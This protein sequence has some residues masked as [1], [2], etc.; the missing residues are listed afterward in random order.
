MDVYSTH[1]WRTRRRTF[2]R[3]HPTCVDDGAKATEADHVPPRAL[4]LAAG[5]HDPDADQWL[6]PRC[7][8]CHS[9]K[10]KLTDQPLLRRWREGEDAHTLCDEAMTTEGG[11][12]PLEP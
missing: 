12:P 2:L 1:Q 4:L 5:I 7:Q 11:V 9:R 3:A 8:P 6:R 10:T